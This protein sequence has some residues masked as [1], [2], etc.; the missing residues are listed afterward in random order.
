MLRKIILE[1]LIFSGIGC[2]LTI[3]SE[4][5][6]YARE[7]VLL[8]CLGHKMIEDTTSGNI[9]I[10]D[11]D[12]SKGVYRYRR[13]LNRIPGV[14]SQTEVGM[15]QEQTWGCARQIALRTTKSVIS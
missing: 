13:V 6:P 8:V 12:E 14:Y 11:E 10:S 9:A 2:Q 15:D 3:I 1:K 5:S 7:M 4:Y